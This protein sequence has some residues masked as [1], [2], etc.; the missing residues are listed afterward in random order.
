MCAD[1][2]LRLLRTFLYITGTL[3]TPIRHCSLTS[4]K[5]V[6]SS[7]ITRDILALQ[8]TW[9]IPI[10]SF[11]IIYFHSRF[12]ISSLFSTPLA[13]V[14]FLHFPPLFYWS[15]HCVAR[16]DSTQGGSSWGHTSTTAYYLLPVRHPL[17]HENIFSLRY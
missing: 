3:K 4:F 15:F 11:C 8:R 5:A 9:L 10:F 6:H 17:P 1:Y 16:S 13:G 12:P 14:I 7:G 2:R